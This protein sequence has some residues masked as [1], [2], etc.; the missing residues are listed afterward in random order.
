MFGRYVTHCVSPV[1]KFLC[2]VQ[3][4]LISF[5]KAKMRHQCITSGARCLTDA[6]TVGSLLTKKYAGSQVVS[7]NFNNNHLFKKKLF[8]TLNEKHIRFA[9]GKLTRVACDSPNFKWQEFF[10]PRVCIAML[11]LSYA[12][13]LTH[14]KGYIVSLTYTHTHTHTHTLNTHPYTSHDTQTPSSQHTCSMQK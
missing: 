3:L 10:F 9:I 12:H 2:V 11:I 4:E 1:T 6:I 7:L 8:S 5:L 14:T 13:R